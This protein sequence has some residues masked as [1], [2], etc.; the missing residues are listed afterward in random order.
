[1]IPISFEWDDRK[2]STNQQKHKVSFEEAQSVFFDEYAIEYD[3]P[4]HSEAEDRYLMMGLS[5]QVRVLVVSYE[6][7]EDS[8]IIRIISARKAT[9]KEQKT[10][11]GEQ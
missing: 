5:Y 9:I 8:S 1:M 4:D 3:D 11:T 7:K 10:Y 2:N 6:L